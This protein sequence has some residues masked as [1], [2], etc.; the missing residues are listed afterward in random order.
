MCSC[1]FFGG[2]GPPD[3]GQGDLVCNGSS[4]KVKFYILADPFLHTMN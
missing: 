1:V 2:W 3:G 4:Q